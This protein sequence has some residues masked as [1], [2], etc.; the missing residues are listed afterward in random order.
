MADAALFDAVAQ[1]LQKRTPFDS[2]QAR[3]TLRLA[4]KDAGLEAKSITPAQMRVVLE[5]VLPS[6]LRS[7]GVRDFDTVCASLLT[8]VDAVGADVVEASDAPEDLF[9][10]TRER[11]S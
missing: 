2:L 6:E 3:G 7:R 8:V 9:R 5:R 1:A 4:L 11:V 10:R